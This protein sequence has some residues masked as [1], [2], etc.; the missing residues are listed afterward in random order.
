M[1]CTKP[2]ASTIKLSKSSSLLDLYLDPKIIYS[3]YPKRNKS[4]F[5]ASQSFTL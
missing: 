3:V 4:L 1:H 5:Y 2:V